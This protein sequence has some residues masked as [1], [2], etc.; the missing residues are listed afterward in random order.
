[1]FLPTKIFKEP[2]L[3]RLRNSKLTPDIPTKSKISITKKSLKK[4]QESSEDD[5]TK[6]NKKK[7]KKKR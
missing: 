4:T 1:M 2:E 6:A 3:T 7:P 5:E